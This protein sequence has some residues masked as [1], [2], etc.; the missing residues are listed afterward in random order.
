[1]M[2]LYFA[3]PLFS[4]AERLF[5]DDLAQRLEAHGFTVFLPQR[6]GVEKNKPP[7]DAMPPEERRQALFHLDTQQILACDIF[8]FVLDGRV[9]DEGA[10]VELGIAYCQRTLQHNRKLL[11]GLQTDSRAAFLGSKLNPMIRVPLDGIA[12]DEDILFDMLQRYQTTGRI[13]VSEQR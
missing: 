11:L 5:N 2:L 7:Y 1:M 13:H 6:D 8:L 9:P 12:P 3:A 4:R 10:C